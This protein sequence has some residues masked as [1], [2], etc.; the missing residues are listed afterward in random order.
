MRARA[1]RN[2]LAYADCRKVNALPFKTCI[3]YRNELNLASCTNEIPG[4]IIGEKS[5]EGALY[6]CQSALLPRWD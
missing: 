6:F 3:V 2:I 4:E 5:L 1:P